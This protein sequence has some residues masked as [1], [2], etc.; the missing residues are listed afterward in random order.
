MR[1]LL[2]M[3]A[4][5]LAAGG[6]DNTAFAAP[7]GEKSKKSKKD[8]SA[9]EDADDDDDEDGGDDDDDNADEEWEEAEKPQLKFFEVN[10]YFRARAEWFENMD[11]NTW[12]PYLTAPSPNGT[13]GTSRVQPPVTD[14]PG[15]INDTWPGGFT[16]LTANEKQQ[17][18]NDGKLD[19]SLLNQ[20]IYGAKGLSGDGR[21]GQLSDVESR[22]GDSALRSVNMRLRLNPTINVS[23]DIRILST[24][25]IFDNLVLGSTPDARGVSPINALSP[26]PPFS[27]TAAVPSDGRN[28]IID[29][30]RVKRVWAE[31]MTPLGQLRFG[32]MASQWGLGVLANASNC[33]DCDFGSDVD[34][35]MFATGIPKYNLYIVPAYDFVSTGFTTLNPEQ[36]G[37]NF[38]D[39]DLDNSDDVNQFVLAIAKRDKDDQIKEALENDKVVVNGGMYNVYRQQ[40]NDFPTF[41]QEQSVFDPKDANSPDKL[42]N[43]VDRSFMIRRDLKLWVGDIWLKILYRKFRLELEAIMISGAFND[44]TSVNTA[45]G[46]PEYRAKLSD[47]CVRPGTTQRVLCVAD[48]NPLEFSRNRVSIFQWSYVIQMEHKFLSDRLT[49]AFEHGMASGDNHSG[50]GLRPLYDNDRQYNNR[51][52]TNSRTEA[53]L[54]PRV[55]ELENSKQAQ[56][57]QLRQIE[58]TA[59]RNSDAYRSALSDYQTTRDE[60]G[61]ASDRLAQVTSEKYDTS[62]NNFR[63]NQAYRIDL[64][65][66]RE[67]IGQITDA[68]YFKPSVQYN[69]TTSFA[70]RLDAIYSRA[71]FKE[72]T[73]GYNSNLGLEFDVSAMY[74]SDDGF[75]VMLQ[76]GILL[77]FAGLDNLGTLYRPDFTTQLTEN[78]TWVKYNPNGFASDGSDSVRAQATTGS[79]DRQLLEA[80]IAQRIRLVLGVVF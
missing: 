27:Q 41:S 9:D 65:L 3:L 11:L 80:A 2:L 39:Y 53:Q 71:M 56:E 64:I 19:P 61:R 50:L 47:Q 74:A 20:P 55:A 37:L 77:P 79:R 26:L 66:W 13:K 22:S 44:P 29:S 54:R 73:P 76:Y 24:I 4:L 7:K 72:S 25:D 62:I 68:I 42:T 6:L 14:R 67:I 23:D 69:V 58:S 63:M 38:P 12:N 18:V 59:G 75:N 49:V 43:A 60:Y 34:R 30:I 17:L 48:L 8:K 28:G 45:V 32:R 16:E 70:L 40:T 57:A 5:A 52:F 1:V 31:V 33:L 36:N 35:I 78:N 15:Y 21:G 46:Q 51:S 10:G